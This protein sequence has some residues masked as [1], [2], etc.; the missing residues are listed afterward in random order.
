MNLKNKLVITITYILGVLFPLIEIYRSNHL[1]L[2]DYEK[3]EYFIF[4][5][6]YLITYSIIFLVLFR[7]ISRFKEGTLFSIAISFYFI[8]YQK[9]AVTFFNIIR[10]NFSGLKK[11]DALKACQKLI[12]RNELC[13]IIDSSR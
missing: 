13:E 5:L 3:I 2:F 10:V 1:I 11:S 8:Y 12:A 7:R 9:I 4:S 6:F